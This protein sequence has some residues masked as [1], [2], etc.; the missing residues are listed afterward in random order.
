MARIFAALLPPD[1]VVAHL[2]E[3]ID[4]VRTAHPHLRWVHPSRWHVTLE[5][6]GE[7]GRHEVDRQLRRWS[8][9]AGR[10]SPLTLALAGAGTF[11]AP[12]RARV[13][14][15]GLTG[16][17]DAWARLAG[18]QE[19][20]HLT[21]ARTRELADLTNLAAELGSYAGPPW[22]ANEMALVESHLKRS[23]GP[24]YVPLERF[25]LTGVAR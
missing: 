13:L 6:L 1:D 10:C 12:W 3:H 14:W 5:F 25:S 15:T 22:V 18:Y 23:A 8:V 2:D 4:G 17:V 24:R 21:L 16:D 19:Q 20:P 7:C 9:R 11:P